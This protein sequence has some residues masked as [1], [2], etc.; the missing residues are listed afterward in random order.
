MQT[1]PC[2]SA[3]SRAVL[4]SEIA[5]DVGV[6]HGHLEIGNNCQPGGPVDAPHE[7]FLL[8]GLAPP[9]VCGVLRRCN[10]VPVAPRGDNPGTV[11]GEFWLGSRRWDGLGEYGR[12]AAGGGDRPVVFRPAFRGDGGR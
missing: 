5:E 4:R 12:S 9:A 1:E 7:Y 8:C 2:A 11:L 6:G 10:V 3:A